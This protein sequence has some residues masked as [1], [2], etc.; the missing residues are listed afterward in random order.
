MSE[1]GG[2]GYGD[3]V[4]P[5]RRLIRV[6][7][8]KS[9]SLAERL[10]GRLHALAWRTPVHG[11][12]LRGHYP[13]KLYDVPADPIEGMVRLGGAMLDGEIVWQGESVTIEGYDFRPGALSAAFSDHLQSFAWR[14]GRPWVNAKLARRSRMV[15]STTV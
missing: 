9:H 8:D 6:E 14:L 10:A 3:S 4:E 1:G 12:R 7:H 13:L 15:S 11:L 2:P 5:G